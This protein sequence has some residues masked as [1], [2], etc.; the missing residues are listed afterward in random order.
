MEHNHGSEYQVKTVRRDGTEKLSGWMN[1]EQVALAMAAARRLQGTAYWLQ[2]RN[3]LCPNCLDRE[4][5]IL[6][7]TLVD[8]PS[9]RCS[10][11]DSR[12]LRAVG[13]T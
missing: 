11:H 2:E 10:P 3:I 1:Q 9:P 8:I 13:R 7:Y 12:Y 4:Q 6:E 5:R